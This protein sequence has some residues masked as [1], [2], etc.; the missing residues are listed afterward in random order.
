MQTTGDYKDNRNN[1][2]NKITKIKQISLKRL[3][4]YRLPD[5]TGWKNYPSKI[6]PIFGIKIFKIIYFF[7]YVN[8][9]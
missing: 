5:L 9:S 8:L 2:V 1:N 3:E 6:D 4:Y 7:M